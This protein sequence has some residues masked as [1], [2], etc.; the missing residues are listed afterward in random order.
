MRRIESRID[1]GSAEFARNREHTESQL[2]VL[3]ARQQWAIDGGAGRAESIER[4]LS[5]GK[6][7]TRDRIDV[8]VVMTSRS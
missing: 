4:H 7:M 3:R 2:D 1:P 5:R 8:R 6:I